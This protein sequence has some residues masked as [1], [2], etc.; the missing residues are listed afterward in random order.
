MLLKLKFKE[1]NY[2]CQDYL[3]NSDNE[4]VQIEHFKYEVEGEGTKGVAFCHH[5]SYEFDP[6]E[7]KNTPVLFRGYMH[8]EGMF[9][10]YHGSFL[11]QED[12]VCNPSGRQTRGSIVDANDELVMMTGSYEYHFDSPFCFDKEQKPQTD[13]SRDKLIEVVF[14]VE[15]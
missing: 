9:N 6:D 5:I 3:S 11:S 10:N 15:V 4:P 1:V 7:T 12:G 14:D 8:F 2:S 13:R